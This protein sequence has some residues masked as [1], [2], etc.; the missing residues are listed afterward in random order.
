[1]ILIKI[2]EMIPRGETTYSWKSIT[3]NTSYSLFKNTHS[4]NAFQKKNLQ[5]QISGGKK[6]DFGVV[7]DCVSLLFLL[8]S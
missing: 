7:S 6:G 2:L 8:A 1:M 5:I 3:I 4:N